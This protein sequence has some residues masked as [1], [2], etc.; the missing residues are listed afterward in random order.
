MLPQRGLSGDF[1][2]LLGP[3]NSGSHSFSPEVVGVSLDNSQVG[4]SYIRDYSASR[5]SPE[6]AWGLFAQNELSRSGTQALQAGPAQ[7][8]P[9]FNSGLSHSSLQGNIFRGEDESSL[10][11]TFQPPFDRYS[12]PGAYSATLE[13]SVSDYGISRPPDGHYQRSASVI[14]NASGSSP[15]GH[16]L[17]SGLANVN[18]S[19]DEHEATRARYRARHPSRTRSR[20]DRSSSNP[21]YAHRDGKQDLRPEIGYSQAT[22]ILT[23][24]AA[25][26]PSGEG[27]TPPSFSAQLPFGLVYDRSNNEGFFQ[28]VPLLKPARFLTNDVF[29][30]LQKVQRR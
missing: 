28:L 7:G 22:D 8:S 13:P 23:Q 12:E 11:G 29:A 2:Q 5:N 20:R 25:L 19:R 30:V 26:P 21:Y 17:S 3:V 10:E 14:S 6:G 18:L 4:T 27:Y 9:E 16:E 1:N 24:A 15:Y